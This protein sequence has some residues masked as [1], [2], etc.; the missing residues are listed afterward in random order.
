M[1]AEQRVQEQATVVQATR[2]QQHTE[3]LMQ[4]Q[5]S[6][7]MTMSHELRSQLS[8]I[9]GMAELL[10]RTS[11]TEHQKECTESILFAGNVMTALVSNLLDFSKI[12]ANKMVLE[13][14]PYCLRECIEKVAQSVEINAEKRNIEL[15]VHVDQHVPEKIVGDSLRMSQVLLNLV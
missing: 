9:I 10:S 6:F 4:S 13:A 15:I 14:S 12:E 11:L 8:G 7:F 3:N 1:A 2:A 5:E